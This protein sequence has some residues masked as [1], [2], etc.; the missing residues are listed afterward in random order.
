MILGL[1]KP[2]DTSIVSQTIRNHKKGSRWTEDEILQALSELGVILH[3]PYKGS[4][5]ETYLVE[6][7]NGVQTRTRLESVLS[8]HTS[9][10]EYTTE[11]INQRLKELG[12]TLAEE[13]KG[14]ISKRHLIAFDNGV[15]REY[16]LAH[17][18]YGHA[19]G[20]RHTK[21]TVN[22]KL[23]EYG[24]VLAED[25][26]GSVTRK[27]LITFANGATKNVVLSRVMGGHST[28]KNHST[29][30]INESIAKY[31]A[32]LAE[33]FK[34]NVAQKHLVTFATGITKEVSLFSVMQGV[35][36]G[37]ENTTETINKRL[38]EFDAILQEPFK[39]HIHKKH[40]ILFGCGHSS[41]VSLN[42]VLC[43]KGC[44]SCSGSGFNIGKPGYLYFLAVKSEGGTLYKI[45]ITNKTVEYRYRHEQVDYIKVALF[46]SEDGESI[47][48]SERAILNAFSSLKYKGSSPFRYTGI[49]E[50]FIRD[51]S[52]DDI[53]TDIVESFNLVKVEHSISIEEIA[54]QSNS[55]AS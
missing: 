18:L 17:V 22:K 20:K 19:V 49:T 51:I 45:G 39:G 13:F 27:H 14:R 30:T 41:N 36:L 5:R 42:N 6:F 9:G 26:K 23:A 11:T 54:L 50:V 12:A 8:G 25:F 47:A 21:E 55:E 33:E 10:I 1:V 38:V 53:F 4:T 52:D 40:K 29:K 46:Y 3:E 44:A 28:G 15:T 35:S 32:V 43:G 31:G 2:M 48:S 24:A 37:K 34:D 16:I 7:S